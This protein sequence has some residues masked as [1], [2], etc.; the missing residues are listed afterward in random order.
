MN[1]KSP[2][3]SDVCL[4]SIK[5][6]PRASKTVVVGPEGEFLKIRLAAPPTEGKANQALIDFLSQYLS[7]PKANIEIKHGL[8]SKHKLI[9]LRHCD[10]KRVQ[11]LFMTSGSGRTKSLE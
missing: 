6:V 2:S 10:P 9:Q 11:K 1:T 5:V 3:G 8:A 7:L 4:V